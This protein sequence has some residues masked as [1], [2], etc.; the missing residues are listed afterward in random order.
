MGENLS[1]QQKDRK[2]EREGDGKRR[3]TQQGCLYVTQLVSM[4]KKEE[5]RE[6]RVKKIV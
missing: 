2:K 3:V 5:E 6:R 4:L 1:L